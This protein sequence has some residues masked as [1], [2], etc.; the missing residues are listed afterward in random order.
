M[1]K[2]LSSYCEPGPKL[3]P[4]LCPLLSWVMGPILET[5]RLVLRPMRRDDAPRIQEVFP[6]IEV[7]RYLAS[8]IP[9]PYPDNGAEE[10]LSFALPEME[11][12]KR[13]LWALTEKGGSDELIGLIELSLV[14][15]F[16]RGFWLIPE[17]H[18]KGFMTEAVAAVNDFAFETVG[19]EKLRLGNAEPNVGSHKLKAKSGAILVEHYDDVPYIGGTFRE[20][21]WELTA[22]QWRRNR[23]RFLSGQ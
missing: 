19:M 1:G 11:E 23:I 18:R 21:V 9:W 6:N 3:D 15:E 17:H 4:G 22:D 20:E 12:G 16:N 5:A 7:T 8:A 2:S 10:F 14:G 13:Y